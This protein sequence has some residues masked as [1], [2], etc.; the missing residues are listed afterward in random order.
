MPVVTRGMDDGKHHDGI[1]PDDEEDAIGKTPRQNA[2]DLGT[3]T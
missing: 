3:F 1:V 2:T